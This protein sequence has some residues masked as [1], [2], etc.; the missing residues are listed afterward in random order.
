MAD[1]T[2][3]RWPSHRTSDTTHARCSCRRTAPHL[4]SHSD[5]D[6]DTDTAPR[7][8][9]AGKST[10]CGQ[11]M[12]CTGQVD[13]RSVQKYEKEAKEK[14]RESWFLAYIMDTDEDERAKGKTVQ[15]GR[16]HFETDKKR[17]TILDAPGHKNYVP[18]MI[19]G[20]CQ[21]D[22]GVLV[23]SARK[24]EFETGFERGGQTREHALLAKTLGVRLLIVAI[25]KMDDPTVEW[26]E[27]R[28]RECCDK[29]APFLKQCGYAKK[30]V[31][32][33]PISALK[34]SNVMVRI[35]A[36]TCP[37][38]QGADDKCFFEILDAQPSIDRRSD[39]PLRLPII[40]KYR[41]MGTVIEGKVEQ[42]G[43][44]EG[45]KYMLMPNRTKVVVE[46]ISLDETDVSKAFGGENVRVKLRDIHEDD[47]KPG[48]V[49]SDISNP[50]PVV[51]RFE[52]QV[53][54]VELLE[55]KSI[56]SAGYTAVLHCHAIAEVSRAAPAAVR[57]RL[58]P[59]PSLSPRAQRGFVRRLR[60]AL[61]CPLAAFARACAGV[62]DHRADR[63]DRQED[64][65]AH[66]EEADVCQVGYALRLSRT[67]PR[68]LPPSRTRTHTHTPLA[69]VR[70]CRPTW[71]RIEPPKLSCADRKSLRT[72]VS[73]R[74]GDTLRRGVSA[75]AARLSAHLTRLARTRTA[76]HNRRSPARP[77][78]CARRRRGDLY[79]RGRA[80][81][82]R[83]N[84]RELPAAR[85]L[86]PARRGQ[87][88]RHRQ[89]PQAARDARG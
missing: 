51:R 65:Q 10:F 2:R 8:A 42:G 29:L 67:P 15:V 78:P 87:D 59:T 69:H 46:G 33:V 84:L 77:R 47:I 35:D 56:F 40:D 64:G 50:A 23:I 18:N 86:H 38:Y 22:I 19:A 73:R 7:R 57:A 83:R 17:Y 26:S 32:T 72:L 21:A 74:A 25:N 41:D 14:N 5:S 68:P 28:Y 20:A 45:G 48:Y 54:V 58:A 66:Q 82:L 85:T 27:E 70:L 34:A 63:R 36:A 6:S 60:S 31:V 4:P 76:M 88:D 62:R 61:A 55:H 44:V 3:G 81:H 49:L 52:A 37:W 80:N 79:H 75:A 16:A 71:A 1:E 13:E 43:L 12:L 9:D 30:D 11:M 39:A 89:D 24:G 53:I